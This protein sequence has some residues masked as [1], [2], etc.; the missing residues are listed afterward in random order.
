VTTAVCD[1]SILFKLVVAEPDSGQAEALV[2][3]TRVLVPEFVF[4]EVGNALWARV[5]WGQLSAEES[6]RLLDRLITMGFDLR[7]ST[8]YATRALTIGAAINHPIYDCVYLALAESERVPLVTA[9]SRLLAALRRSSLQT[10][11]VKPLSALA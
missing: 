4:L 6:A 5:G 2:R 1:A 9:D 11:E 7:L 3:V 8:P 10:V